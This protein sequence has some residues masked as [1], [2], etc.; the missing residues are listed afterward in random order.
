MPSA[1]YLKHIPELNRPLISLKGIGP[2][3]AE[4]L[5]RKGLHTLIDLLWL[6]PIRYEDRRRVLPIDRT[7]DGMRVWVRGKVISGREERFFRSGKRLFRIG[8]QDETGTLDLLWFHYKKAYLST[9]ARQGEMLMAYGCI[10]KNRGKTQMIHPDI[11]L[12]E[13]EREKDLLGFH[14]VYS[15]IHGIPEQVIRS[16]IRHVLNQYKEFL[17]DPVPRKVTYPL[18]LPEFE[19]A[20]KGVHNPSRELSFGRLRRFRTKYHQRLTFDRFFGIMLDIAFRKKARE[21]KAGPAFCVPRRLLSRVQKCFPFAL[22]GGQVRAI[23]EIVRDLSRNEPMNRLL[24]GDVG[25]GKTVVAAVAASLT[26]MN[27]WQVAIMVPT[28]VLARQHY[29]YFEGLP[30]RLGFRS[31]LLTGA[32]KKPERLDTYEKIRLGEVNLIIGT[33]ALIQEDLSFAKL[34]LVVIDEQHRFGVKQRTLLDQ[35]GINPHL[36]VMTATPIPRTLALTVYADLDIS[37]I[38]EYPEGRL[39]VVTRLMDGSQKRRVLDTLNQ[40]MSVGEQAMVICPVIEG[41]E[42]MDL[43]NA[44]ETHEKLRKIFVPRFRVELIHGRMSS[45][46]KDC[47]MDRFRHGLIDL[48]V[49]TTVIEVGVDVPGATVMVIQNP[50]RFGLTQLHQLR[51]RVG[52][53]T[54]RG[55]C[56]LMLSKPLSAQTLSRLRILVQSH[57]GFEIAQRDLEMRGQGELMGTRQS[58]VGELDFREMFREPELLLAA[59]KEADALVAADPTLSRPENRFLRVIFSQKC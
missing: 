8:I 14:P 51:G 30:K 12:A 37:L 3:R 44:L 46:E 32:L 34:G 43:K 29:H 38:S 15:V 6:C 28:Q 56:F 58:G 42:E 45:E 4:F 23:D 40:R 36:L 55:C 54:Q 5:A 47:I 10:R 1:S 7:T 9:F 26:V 53:G 25:C 19:E 41:S 57:D 33:Q 59:K 24:Q 17:V 18:A 50:E 20:I 22:T 11:G 27:R 31:V 39:P 16:A 52:R 21:G 13:P 49:G 35:K 2:K 48:L